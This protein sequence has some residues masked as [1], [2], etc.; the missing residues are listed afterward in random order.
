M[1]WMS[2]KLVIL[3][4][5][6]DGPSILAGCQSGFEALREEVSFWL[7]LQLRLLHADSPLSGTNILGT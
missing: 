1:A 7:S 4:N 3:W 5:Q 6:R 2:G